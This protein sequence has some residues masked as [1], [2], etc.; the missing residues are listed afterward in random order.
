MVSTMLVQMVMN[1]IG[2]LF[3]EI[4]LLKH[5]RLKSTKSLAKNVLALNA[6]DLS[7]LCTSIKSKWITEAGIIRR[8]KD[9]REYHYS[10]A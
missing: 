4:H 9:N 1:A 2:S 6:T 8:D 10:F 3:N 5:E 7:V